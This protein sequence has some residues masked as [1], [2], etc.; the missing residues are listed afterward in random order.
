MGRLR[1]G[2]DPLDA[3]QGVGSPPRRTQAAEGGHHRD[4]SAVAHGARHF[5]EILGAAKE[6]PPAQPRDG[7]P[8]RVDLTVDAIGSVRA[9]LPGHRH[10]QAGGGDERP[11]AGVG[12]QEG[13]RPVGALRISG[14]QAA[15]PDQRCLLIDTQPAHRDGSP[16]RIGPPDLL[17][18]THDLGEMFALQTEGRAGLLGPGAPLQ[19]EQHRPRGGGGV[20]DVGTR[21]AVQEPGVAGRHHPVGRDMAPQPRHLRCRE[22]GIER[23]P[24]RA[25]QLLRVLRHVATDGRRAPVLP[26]DGGTQG[27]SGGALPCQHGLTLVGEAHRPHVAARLGERVPAGVADRFPQLLGILLDAS[28]WDRTRRDAD[29][30]RGER[31]PVVAEHHRLGRRRSLIDGEDLHAASRLLRRSVP[32][33]ITDP[34]VASSGLSRNAGPRSAVPTDPARSV[35]LMN[36]PVPNR[37]RRA[38]P[39]RDSMR[40]GKIP[41]TRQ[42]VA[43]VPQ[44]RMRPPVPG[45]PNKGGARA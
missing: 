32:E 30:D 13:A 24:G 45:P 44:H 22:V 31:L 35:G 25:G 28:V 41:V 29:F 39:R 2:T 6:S 40:L 9:E 16:E 10:R 34:W 7:R 38:Y 37:R 11:P 33:G 19:V 20:G 43:R 21:E 23:E 4:A 8:R 42:G 15:L 5:I 36:D 26:R 1:A 27:A 12:Q 3:G 18:T 14:L 17:R